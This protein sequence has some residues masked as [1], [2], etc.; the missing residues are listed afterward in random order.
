MT[1]LA[2]ILMRETELVSRFILIL[3][4]E[5]EALKSGKSDPLAEINGKKINLVD[6]LNQLG[7]NRSQ[8][9]GL[10]GLTSDQASMTTWLAQHPQ[11]KKSATLWQVLIDLAR[12][13]KE[14]HE[15]NGQLISIHLKQTSDALAVLTQHQ[16]EHTL[17]GSNGQSSLFTGSRIVDSA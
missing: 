4:Q 13:A 5:Q 3:K 1:P 8:L 2:G 14:L 10:P 16:Q 15:L 17:Y 7:A 6:Q 11:E 9:T 12:E